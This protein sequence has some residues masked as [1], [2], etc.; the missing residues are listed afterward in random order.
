MFSKRHQTHNNKY[1]YM[2]FKMASILGGSA[3]IGRG[4]GSA[5]WSTRDVFYFGR[6]GYKGG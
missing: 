3:T 6:G 2:K 1:V 5:W 4:N